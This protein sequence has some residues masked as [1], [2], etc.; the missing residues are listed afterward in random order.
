M[1]REGFMFRER[2]SANEPVRVLGGLIFGS[3]LISRIAN[4][5]V[6]PSLTAARQLN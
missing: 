1:L 2:A 3:E 4:Y 5:C 6:S